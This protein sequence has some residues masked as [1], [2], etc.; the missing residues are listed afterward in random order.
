MVEG[1][2]ILVSLW[3]FWF[4]VSGLLLFELFGC[5]CESWVRENKLECIYLIGPKRYFSKLLS[6]KQNNGSFFTSKL[7]ISSTII[8]TCVCMSEFLQSQIFFSWSFNF[9]QRSLMLCLRLFVCMCVLWF[10][11]WLDAYVIDWF[12]RHFSYLLYLRPY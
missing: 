11:E 7:P 8:H 3:I 1:I 2:R 6:D 5:C 10:S 9:R 12:F 4:R